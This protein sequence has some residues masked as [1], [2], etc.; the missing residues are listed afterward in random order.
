MNVVKRIENLL[1]CAIHTELL[2]IIIINMIVV[3]RLLT[4]WSISSVPT[5]STVT[6]WPPWP[7]RA[8]LSP[9]APM[10]IALILDS[11]S[12]MQD[13][14]GNSS[15]SIR[16]CVFIILII[17]R[18]SPVR[19]CLHYYVRWW[20]VQLPSLSQSY[21]ALSKFYREK[22]KWGLDTPPDLLCYSGGSVKVLTIETKVGLWYPTWFTLVPV[23]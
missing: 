11:S 9:T 19:D 3:V 2:S 16:R 6:R 23:L 15:S 8:M 4:K 13:G 21:K 22:W 10:T 20:R 12:T 5:Q 14:P 1:L 17:R 7:H 18:D